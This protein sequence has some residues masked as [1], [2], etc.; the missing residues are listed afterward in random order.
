M[1]GRTI[2]LEN[3]EEVLARLDF[4]VLV[5]PE[6]EDARDTI[7]KRMMRGGK[8]LGVKRNTLTQTV[9]SGFLGATVRSTLHPPRTKGTSWGRYQ[10]KVVG[11]VVTRNAVKKAVERIGERWSGEA[12]S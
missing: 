8:G 4:D 7:V 11:G 6:M 5:Q 9:A 2:R 10:E 1:A 3:L 12:V